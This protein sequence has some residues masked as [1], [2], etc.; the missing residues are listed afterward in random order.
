MK[1]GS[2]ILKFTSQ[3]CGVIMNINSCLGSVDK[4]NNNR[5]VDAPFHLVV[6]KNNDIYYFIAHFLELCS[7]QHKNLLIRSGP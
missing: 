2:Q 7:L 1:I 6:K 4:L 3:F 5:S